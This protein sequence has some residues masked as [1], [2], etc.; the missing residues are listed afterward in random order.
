MLFASSIQVILSDTCVGNAGPELDLEVRQRS[1]EL[2]IG[3]Y[4]IDLYSVPPTR[5]GFVYATTPASRLDFESPCWFLVA[6]PLRFLFFGVI[7]HT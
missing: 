7:G 6:M 3:L 5:R 2:F 4:N 1:K